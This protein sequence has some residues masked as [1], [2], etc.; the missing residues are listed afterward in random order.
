MIKTY[1]GKLDFYNYNTVQV[2]LHESNG[3][4]KQTRFSFP[5]V[6][7]MGEKISKNRKSKF[8]TL[9]VQAGSCHRTEGADQRVA[10]LTAAGAAPAWH[11]D[12]VAA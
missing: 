8:K 2:I 10:N 6:L 1:L 4:S 12:L 9:K 3:A 11:E 5:N 7:C